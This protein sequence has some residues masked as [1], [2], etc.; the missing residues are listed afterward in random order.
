MSMALWYSRALPIHSG[1]NGA[2]IIPVLDMVNHSSTPNA[3]LFYVESHCES[4][5][6]E[7]GRGCYHV[8]V[9]MNRGVQP[10]DSIC[11]EYNPRPNRQ[12]LLHFGFIP[13][14]NPLDLVKIEL[15]PCLVRERREL[16]TA[17]DL[18]FTMDLELKASDEVH[19]DPLHHLSR[20][21]R[22]W[23][24]A[25]IE[26]QLPPSNGDDIMVSKRAWLL[27]QAACLA[28]LDDL[29]PPAS[30]VTRPAAAYREARLGGV[31]GA[32]AS[33]GRAAAW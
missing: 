17:L 29:P 2:G 1:G 14:H 19:V 13:S 4:H 28:W 10:G 18:P 24:H 7:V 8:E 32:A 20:E 21:L 22:R 9:R 26:G 5:E 30:G 25:I 12:W 15:R 16:L 31:E 6:G 3:E 11:F 27:L 33:F 23:L